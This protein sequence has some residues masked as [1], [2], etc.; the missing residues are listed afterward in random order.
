MHGKKPLEGWHTVDHID[1]NPLNNTPENLRWATR[2]EQRANQG[3]ERKSSA[4]KRSK[5]IL[6]REVSEDD[7]AWIPF[8]SVKDAARRLGLHLGSVSNVVNGR[9]KTVGNAGKKYEFMPDKAAAE[10]EILTD[11]D[12]HVEE[13]RPV[14]KWKFVD[15]TWVDLFAD[16]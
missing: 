6:G 11:D 8:A 12:G 1:R 4:P 7:A 5:P 13:W 16:L 10:P 3:E 14:K 2:Q 9:C 15:G